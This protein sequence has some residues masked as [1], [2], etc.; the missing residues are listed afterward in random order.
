MEMTPVDSLQIA[1]EFSLTL[2]WIRASS[3]EEKT[4]I[5]NELQQVL[6]LR[7][8]TKREFDQRARTIEEETRKAYKD[9]G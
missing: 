1:T 3:A 2:Q 4:R 7:G 6:V 5:L 9:S 8:V